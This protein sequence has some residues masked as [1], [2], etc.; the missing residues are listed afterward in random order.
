MALTEEELVETALLRYAQQAATKWGAERFASEF[1]RRERE[2][3]WLRAAR[4]KS[5]RAPSPTDE[6][7]VPEPAV[8]SGLVDAAVQERVVET[9]RAELDLD[10]PKYAR[11]SSVPRPPAPEP[12]EGGR[13]ARR[14]R[15][16]R[17]ANRSAASVITPA[18]A[19]R[20][21]PAGRRLYGLDDPRNSD[22]G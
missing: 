5:F 3:Q 2:E 16:A 8:L 7:D 15:R 4:S 12:E 10:R 1:E 14:R 17:L 20:M 6:A 21:S 19:A 18:E 11:H 13:R 22:R 9:G